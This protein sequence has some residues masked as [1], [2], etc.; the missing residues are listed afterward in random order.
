MK[1]KPENYLNDGYPPFWMEVVFLTLFIASLFV[2]R[3]YI[4][5]FFKEMF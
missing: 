4:I 3:D 1:G 5:P 2:I